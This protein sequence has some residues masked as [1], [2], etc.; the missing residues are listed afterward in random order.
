MSNISIRV[1]GI[2]FDWETDLQLTLEDINQLL[3]R[4]GA[5]YM[6]TPPAIDGAKVGEPPQQV[7]NAAVASVA[8]GLHVNSIAST[9]SASS[10]PDLAI[11]AAAYL[12]IVQQKS[13]FTRQELLDAMKEA[14]KFYNANMSGNLTKILNGLVGSRLNQVGQN[15]YSMSAAEFSKVE[16]QLAQSA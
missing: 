12:Q 11:A 1:G 13:S 16:T 9:M 15:S 2:S 8:P 7:P 4:I 14:T 3:D 5:L 6:A 10:G